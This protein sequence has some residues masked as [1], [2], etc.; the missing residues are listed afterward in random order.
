MSANGMHMT[1]LT[2]EHL[3]CHR[4]THIAASS[5]ESQAPI[6]EEDNANTS[7]GDSAQSGALL[8]TDA[9]TINDLC[10]KTSAHVHMHGCTQSDCRSEEEDGRQQLS[11][12]TVA[13]NQY[14]VTTSHVAQT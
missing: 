6:T 1:D 5:V 8:A 9:G 3:S 7:Q 2:F 11:R 4:N 12:L 10:S 13:I 14:T